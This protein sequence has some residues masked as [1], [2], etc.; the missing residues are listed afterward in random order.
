MRWMSLVQ[1]FLVPERDGRQQG[2]E[3]AAILELANRRLAAAGEHQHEPHNQGCSPLM[4][5]LSEP[6]RREQAAIQ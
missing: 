3:L 1:L 5:A 2:L 6:I 4:A